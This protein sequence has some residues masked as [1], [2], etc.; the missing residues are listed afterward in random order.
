MGTNTFQ[1]EEWATCTYGVGGPIAN[2]EQLNIA[3]GA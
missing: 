3:P 2:Y 1:V